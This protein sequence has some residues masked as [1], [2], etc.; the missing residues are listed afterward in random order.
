LSWSIRDIVVLV[1][2]SNGGIL[3]PR[4]AFIRNGLLLV[5]VGSV[6]LLSSCG[7]DKTTDTNGDDEDLL[8]QTV[9]GVLQ[10]YTE[11]LEA[12]DLEGYTECLD[13]N[14]R[15]VFTPGDA[16][17]LGLPEDEPWWLRIDDLASTASMFADDDLHSI[18]VDLTVVDQDTITTGEDPIITVQ[19][20]LAIL[21]ILIPPGE[22]PDYLDVTE[23]WLFFELVRDA[24]DDRLWVISEIEEEYQ[25]PPPADIGQID[26]AIVDPLTFGD[27]KAIFR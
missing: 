22:E 18:Q 13:D 5:L 24:D 8:R 20:E 21:V 14:Y 2:L 26:A 4:I 27:I 15:F 6:M 25:T 17:D 11:S 16:E 9:Q 12:A 19:V 10:K 3:M 7:D 23:T 1:G